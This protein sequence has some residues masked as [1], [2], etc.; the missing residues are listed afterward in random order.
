MVESLKSLNVLYIED[1]PIIQE[2][3]SRLLQHF[4]HTVY[5][6]S[7]GV[8]GLDLFDRVTAHIVVTDIQLPEMN[9]LEMARLIRKKDGDTPIFITTAFDD[10]EFLL[11][12]IP[13]NLS[14]YL[15]KPVTY[16]S[17]RQVLTECAERLYAQGQ[18]K[19]RLNN[20]LFYSSLNKVVISDDEPLISLTKKE[21][22][23]LELLIKHRS[24]LVSKEMIQELIYGNDLMTEAALKNLLHKLRTKIGKDQI[25]SVSNLGVLLR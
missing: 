19:V 1:E 6:A 22:E 25:I 23:L 13:L 10:R 15:I 17:I 24:N 4:F 14:G 3:T 21:A 7:S 20:G 9:G 2:Q 16:S 8:E 18:L 5:C 12:A 11:D